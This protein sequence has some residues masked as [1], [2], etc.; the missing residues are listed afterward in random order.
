MPSFRPKADIMPSLPNFVLA[1]GF[2]DKALEAYNKIIEID[3]NNPYVHISLAEFY[4][5]QGNT[6]KLLKSLKPDLQIPDLILT[7]KFRFS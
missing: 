6:T 7:Q 3:P 4:K 5:K 2:N 1:N